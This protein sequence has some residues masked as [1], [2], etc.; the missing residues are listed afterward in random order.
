[1]I[2]GDGDPTDVTPQKFFETLYKEQRPKFYK[3][4]ESGGS[5]A[6]NDKKGSGGGKTITRER[7]EALSQSERMKIS[8]E[9]VQIVD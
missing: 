9:G 4:S 7:F 1:V 6:S 3:A 8:K 2:D 5:G